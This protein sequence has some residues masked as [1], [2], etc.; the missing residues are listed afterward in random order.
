MAV[1]GALMLAVG[2]AAD[3]FPEVVFL[4]LGFLDLGIIT[5][6]S[7]ARR[8]VNAPACLLGATS[9]AQLGTAVASSA[10]AAT[11]IFGV[12]SEV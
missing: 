12:T 4:R 10:N 2:G 9:S 8:T 3:F 11:R 1:G 7:G 5:G 6:A